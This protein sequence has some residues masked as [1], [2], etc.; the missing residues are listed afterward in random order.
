MTANLGYLCILVFIQFSL[1]TRKVSCDF[2]FR[3]VSLP[4]EERVEDLVSRLTLPELVDQM[5]KGGGGGDGGPVLPI[6]RLGIPEYW[7]GTEC[8]HGD[9]YGNSTAFPQAIGLSATFK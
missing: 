6:K 7:W 9:I 4:F 1:K 3:N 2:P 8:L 5:T